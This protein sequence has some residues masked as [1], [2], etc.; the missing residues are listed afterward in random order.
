MSNTFQVDL[1]PAFQTFVR[2]IKAALDQGTPAATLREVQTQT[3]AY[4]DQ[5]WDM[6][7]RLAEASMQEQIDPLFAVLLREWA[8]G[9]ALALLLRHVGTPLDP[10]HPGLQ[11]A[12]DQ[13]LEEQYQ[14]LTAELA[15]LLEAGKKRR[16]Q[17]QQ[18]KD[19]SWHTVALKAIEGQ[20]HHQQQWQRSAFEWMDRQQQTN[21]Q[22][23]EREQRMVEQSQHANQQW[24]HTALTG[25]QQAQLGIKQWYDFATTTQQHVTNM[26]A[27][28]EQ[29]Q[30][31]LVE[32][33]VRQAHTRRWISRLIV[34]GVILC[35]IAGSIGCSYVA[36]LNLFH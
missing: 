2:T 10:S 9:E 11:A 8:K 19:E 5:N 15:F 6:L 31:A 7:K 36:L 17:E 20:H 1:T 13:K 12:F 25:V 30:S 29:R 35:L 18:A 4:L 32:Q 26:L 16:A 14:A 21:Q 34:F 23:F 33:A 3:L 24:A 22:W 28:S 27:G